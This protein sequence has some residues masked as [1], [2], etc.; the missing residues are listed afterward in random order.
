MHMT[1]YGTDFSSLEPFLKARDTDDVLN[2][3]HHSNLTGI[4]LDSDPSEYFGDN[5]VCLLQ[6]D[7]TEGPYCMPYPFRTPYGRC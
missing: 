6:P 1:E 4:D 3:D 7:V 5:T 2:T